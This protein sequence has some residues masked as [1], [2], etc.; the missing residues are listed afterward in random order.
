MLVRKERENKKGKILHYFE[1]EKYSL[2]THE[3]TY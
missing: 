1:K 3:G 2:Y